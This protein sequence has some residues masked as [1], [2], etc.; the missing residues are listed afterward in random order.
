[1]VAAIARGERNDTRMI[2]DLDC[3]ELAFA[4]LRRGEHLAR[5]AVHPAGQ[6]SISGAVEFPLFEAVSEPLEPVGERK[7]LVAAAEI[8]PHPV[9][10]RIVAATSR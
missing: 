7:Q 6:R 5:P 4:S 2:G 10:P 9:R 8:E 3:G 1:M